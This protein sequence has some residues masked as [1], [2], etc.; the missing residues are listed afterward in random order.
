MTTLKEI[1]QPLNTSG[2]PKE[3][4]IGMTYPHGVSRQYTAD[5]RRI[6]R[7]LAKEV[8]QRVMPEVR[9]ALKE[10]KDSFDIFEGMPTVMHRDLFADY[11]EFM[12]KFDSDVYEIID[13]SVRLDDERM[14]GLSDVLVALRL[15]SNN[16][17][18][19]EGLATS[20]AEKTEYQNDKN[21]T[22]QIE[23]QLGI[24]ISLPESELANVDDWIAENTQLIQNL[25]TEYLNRIQE[26]IRTGFRESRT[27]R[28][29]AKDIQKA[30]GITWRRAQLIAVNE[31]GNL[32][33]QINKERN[34][35]LGIDKAEWISSRDERVRGN[36][37]GLYPD[38]RPSHW[39][40]DGK[41]FK[42]SEGLNGELPGQPIRCRCF[43]RSIIE[44]D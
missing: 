25:Q 37:G 1:L 24:A 18:P 9:K 31:V 43:G 10:R 5:L 23:K 35:E 30:T 34:E 16:L 15:I 19:G 44:L 21:I 11:C 33:A 40:N 41:I 6:V 27:S 13:D 36:P 4:K 38:A 14:D 17:I 32:N 2:K 3:V 12:P 20:Y 22:R 29:I 26:S 7:A 8:Q 39:A 42:W 28:Q